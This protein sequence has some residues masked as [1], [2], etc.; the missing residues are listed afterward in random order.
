MSRIAI[1]S[2]I[3]RLRRVIVHEPG[4]EIENVTPSGATDALYDDIL[5]L[6]PALREHRQMTAVLGQVAE[7]R[8]LTDLLAEVLVE[9]N[10]RET[11]VTSLCA[12]HGCPERARD[13]IGHE[14]ATL[15]RHLIE[16][17]PMRKDSLAKYLDP[18]RFD[19]PPMSNTFFMRDAAM[20]V[21]GCAVIGAMASHVRRS[22]A[23][24]MRALFQHHP[25]LAAPL[26]FDGA[27]NVDPS[28]TV[29]G[30][31]VLVL[32]EDL[33]V[34]GHSERS[35]VAGIDRLVASFAR[36]GAIRD[37]VV[38]VLPK[39]RATIHLDMVFTM[40]DEGLCVVHKPLILDEPRCRAIH[41]RLADGG[42]AAIHDHD[43]LLPALDA[44]GLSL[45]AVPCGGDDPVRQEREQW[46]SGANFFTFS[47][48]KVIGYG[49]NA[50]TYEALSAR[51]FAVMDAATAVSDAVD[52]TAPGRV[53]V[54]MSGAESSRGGGGCRC[55]TLPVVRDAV[56]WSA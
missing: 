56:D 11:L 37:V 55:M 2:E 18:G 4:Q 3:G 49:R 36:Q 45:E 29:E 50:A 7:V 33:V 47:P 39:M 53:A 16:G 5:F 42:V 35:S 21:G 28:V 15:A 25:D 20:A 9:N 54:A 34:V 6:Q 32:R 22:E 17:T 44:L 43:G 1:G 46:S 27:A 10:V 19:L 24:V 51:G 40:V 14:P 41:L 26:C 38:V 48:G 8:E 23:L 31:D 12:L 52:L 30:G 13:L